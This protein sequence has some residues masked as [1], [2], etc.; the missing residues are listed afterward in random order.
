[1]DVTKL[2]A[3][4]FAALGLA[5]SA[6]SGHAHQA[7]RAH[8]VSAHRVH[9]A[10]PLPAIFV[11]GHGWGHGIGMAQYGAYG[12]ALHGWAYDKIVGHYY[13]GT[14]LGDSDLRKVRVL[15][16]PSSRRVVIS[17]RSPFVVRD[18]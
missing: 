17:S 8:A 13:P 14:T 15:L 3:T 5:G 10:Q 7:A 12:Y 4:I 6:A 11:V 1:M 2:A 16:T 9:R 18:G